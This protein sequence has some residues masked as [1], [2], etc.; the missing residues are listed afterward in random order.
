MEKYVHTNRK[1][2][3]FYTKTS[4]FTSVTLSD[5]FRISVTM[6]KSQRIKQLK[7]IVTLL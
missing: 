7:R 4:C 3:I 6:P 5:T 2:G 1:N